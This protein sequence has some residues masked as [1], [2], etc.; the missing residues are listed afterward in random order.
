MKYIIIILILIFVNNCYAFNELCHL[1]NKTMVPPKDCEKVLKFLNPAC[2][3]Y[4]CYYYNLKGCSLNLCT[5]NGQCPETMIS[6][7]NNKKNV[8]YV[9]SSK[10]Q[11]PKCEI[12][13]LHILQRNPL[14]SKKISKKRSKK[15]KII[16]FVYDY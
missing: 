2:Q 13:S 16:E 14:I 15:N 1:F 10:W 7:C 12:D 8:L 6:N 11:V 3:P 4:N 5:C 9:L